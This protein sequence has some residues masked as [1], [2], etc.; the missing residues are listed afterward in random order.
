MTSI[1][2]R[3][4]T[5]PR[6]CAHCGKPLR[7]CRRTARYCSALCNHRAFLLFARIDFAIR[8]DEQLTPG[9]SL[10]AALARAAVSSPRPRAGTLHG[11]SPVHG[12]D[13][14]RRPDEQDD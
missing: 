10:A 7:H 6:A 5:A 2:T 3:P 13:G 11:T 1:T 14:A 9:E 4:D 8:R 12:P